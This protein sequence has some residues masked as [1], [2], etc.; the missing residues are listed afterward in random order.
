MALDVFPAKQ[1][2]VWEVIV[3]PLLVM[4]HV[5]R[6][7]TR[8]AFVANYL[9]TKNLALKGALDL[10]TQDR[11]RDEVLNR[12]REET[13]R[14]LEAT[15]KELY[16]PAI[17][18]AQ[19]AEIELE[20]DHAVRLLGVEGDSSDA[21]IRAA[22]ADRTAYDAFLA[23]LDKAERAVSEAAVRTLGSQGD[24]GVARRVHEATDGMRTREADR[25]FGAA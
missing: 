15:P 24:P 6:R 25:V 8:D 10:A 1:I 4:N 16:G 20:M 3:L 22:H 12:I 13:D 2:S 11:T 23:S 7:N 14:I 17:R 9:F 21:L 18:D 19:L 5:A